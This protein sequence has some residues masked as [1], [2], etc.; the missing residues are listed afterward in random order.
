VKR[1]QQGFSLVE[2]LVAITL[3]AIAMISVAP[4]FGGALKTNAVGWD[5]SALNALAKSKLEEVLQYNFNDPRLRVPT[6]S[7]ITIN[8]TTF[9]GQLYL[10]ETPTTQT[11][12]GFTSRY[13]YE[14]VYVVSDFRMADLPSGST[15]DL[16]K[17]TY[18]GDPRWSA[19]SDLKYIVVISASQRSFLQGSPY[20]LAPGLSLGSRG[21][22]IRMGAIKSP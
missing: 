16:T 20:S 12:S 19:Q 17:A 18:D 15:A 8:G 2:V 5:F 7:T 11:V 22:Q 3:M 14:L 6:S 21:K 4:L 9:V 13:P 10:T 1:A